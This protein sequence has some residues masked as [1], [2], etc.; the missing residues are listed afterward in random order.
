MN[1]K[2]TSS[3]LYLFVLLLLSGITVVTAQSDIERGR[4]LFKNK[5]YSEAKPIFE[6]ILN[7]NE[8]NA[9]ANYYL[10]M[11]YWRY[12]GDLD[13][14]S[15]LLETA[16]ENDESNAQYHFLYSGVLGVRAMRSNPIKQ[17]YLA[18]KIRNQLEKTIELEPTH[19]DAR[20]NLIQFYIM[21]PG[22]MGGSIEKAK[23]QAGAL[24]KY[25]AARGYIAY[26]QIATNEKD[27]ASAEN[28]FFKAIAADPSLPGAYHQ[29]GYLYVK[30]KRP[31]DAV[32]Q[33]QKLTDVDPTNANSF[34]SLGD[35]FIANNQLDEAIE[36]FKKAVTLDPTFSASVYNLAQ[37]Y[38]KKNMKEEAK[39]Q[40]R[41]YLALVPSGSKFEKAR[42]KIDE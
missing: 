10:G 11:I 27:D 23:V 13:K 37:C 35:G 6:G 25:N 24:V 32:K 8:K 42:E 15:E 28:Y 4:E 22:F 30:L 12:V 3:W 29:L 33:F 36:S 2:V 1:F 39:T 21:A 14:A 9:E 17:A 5:R 41:R 7:G 16:T 40:Y 18:T 20:Y 19:V 31:A 26:A 34:D 38:E